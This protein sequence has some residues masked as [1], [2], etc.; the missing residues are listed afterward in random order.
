MLTVDLASEAPCCVLDQL[1]SFSPLIDGKAEESP[2]SKFPTAYVEDEENEISKFSL[3]VL[4]F[5]FTFGKQEKKWK[6][7][8][9]TKATIFLG[10]V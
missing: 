1:T 2:L 5:F 6:V 4:V 9:L 7:F 10:P 8:L 3:D